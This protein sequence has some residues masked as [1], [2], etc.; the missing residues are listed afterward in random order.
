VPF[1][2]AAGKQDENL[3][4]MHKVQFATGSPRPV[5]VRIRRA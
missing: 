3:A 5:V 4:G 1:G 2:K